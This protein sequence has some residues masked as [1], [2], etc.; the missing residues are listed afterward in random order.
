MHEHHQGVRLIGD[1]INHLHSI[2]DGIFCGNRWDYLQIFYVGMP[3]RICL[4]IQHCLNQR[5]N[6]NGQRYKY[7]DEIGTLLSIECS[8]SVGEPIQ[9]NQLE[10][11]QLVPHQIIRLLGHV[12]LR[13]QVKLLE[14]KTNHLHQGFYT[15][16][17]VIFWIELIVNVSMVVHL[18]DQMALRLPKVPVELL[19]CIRDIFIVVHKE[20]IVFVAAWSALCLLVITI[21]DA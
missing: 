12:F 18:L 7:L 17:L 4:Y 3:E 6:L 16:K 5:P 11:G 2:N 15:G 13:H 19:I 1:R 21:D 20:T 9:P 10:F 14:L 8:Y